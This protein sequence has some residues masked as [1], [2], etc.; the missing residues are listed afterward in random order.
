MRS[1]FSQIDTGIILAWSLLICVIIIGIPIGIISA[2]TLKHDWHKTYFVKRH[3]ILVVAIFLCCTG[4]YLYTPIV[5]LKVIYANNNIFGILYRYGSLHMHLLATFIGFAAVATRVWL[6]YFDIQ[7]AKYNLHKVWLS[8]MD[9]ITSESNW[10]ESK[11]HTLGNARYLLKYTIIFAVLPSISHILL[12][13][14]YDLPWIDRLLV[15]SVILCIT[16][17]VGWIWHK[18]KKLND[19]SLSI[20]KELLSIFYET[21]GLIISIFIFYGLFYFEIINESMMQ[22]TLFASVSIYAN[23]IL[24]A[25]TILPQQWNKPNTN[26][27]GNGNTQQSGGNDRSRKGK[28]YGH[29]PKMSIGLGSRS[30]SPTVPVQRVNHGWVDVVCTVYG[31]QHLMNH[32]QTE[33]S[34]ETLLFI[35]EVC[36]FGCLVVLL[37]VICYLWFDNMFICLYVS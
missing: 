19:D 34:L 26:G 1:F 2:L 32:L 6:L 12:R 9:P 23:S 16:F 11:Q 3:R 5:C 4:Q 28:R 30:G 22:V 13:N 37:F 36:L 8:A 31:F 14:V 17:V 25:L 33:F 15:T 27:N 35:S 7:L 18:L 29:R 10:F 21:L 24:I 20:E